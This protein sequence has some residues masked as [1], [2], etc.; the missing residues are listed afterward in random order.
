M[1]LRR[2]V[3]F[4]GFFTTVTAD[5]LDGW[6]LERIDPSPGL[7]AD[8]AERGPEPQGAELRDALGGALAAG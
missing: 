3:L 7:V 1:P 6:S 2:F 5:V 4:P 8:R